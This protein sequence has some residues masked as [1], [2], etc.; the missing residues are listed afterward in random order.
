M[1]VVWQL[2]RFDHRLDLHD[3]PAVGEEDLFLTAAL[4]VLGE[5]FDFRAHEF[6]RDPSFFAAFVADVR[7][8]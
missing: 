5:H 7:L 1:D 4:L 2:G 3:A 8:K 6:A